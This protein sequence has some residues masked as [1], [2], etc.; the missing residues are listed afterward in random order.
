MIEFKS[1]EIKSGFDK[2]HPLVKDIVKSVGEWSM[3]YDKKPITLTET[4]STPERDKKLKRLSP[5]HSQGRAVDIRTI[6]MSKQKLILLM[7]TFSD[8]FKHLGYLSQSGQRRLM[9]YHDNGN[10]PHIHL[11]IG[12][13]VIEKYKTKYTWKYPVHKKSKES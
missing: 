2:L 11:A 1:D 5:A 9:Y 8:K 7:Q 6:G 12:L 13:D 4:L 3:A 10:G